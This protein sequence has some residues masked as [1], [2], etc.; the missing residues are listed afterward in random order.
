M[1]EHAQKHTAEP[2]QGEP[3]IPVMEWVVAAFGLMLVLATLVFLVF[4]ALH[5]E[6]TPPDVIVQVGSISPAAAGYLVQFRAINHGGQA[7]E[8]LVVRGELRGDGNII[9]TSE[10]RIDY[11]PADSERR[12]GLYFRIDPR[13]VQLEIR[14]LGYEYP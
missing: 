5:R 12:G 13:Q 6:E 10:T 9:E 4:Q 2:Q 7:A 3:D 11:V 1:G 14:A 8:G